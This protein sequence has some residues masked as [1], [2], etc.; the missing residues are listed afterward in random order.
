MDIR[1]R[2]ISFLQVKGPSLPVHIAKEIGQDSV[3]A[4]AHLSEMASQKKIAISNLKVGGSPLYYLP[5]QENRLQSF[6]HNLHEREQ[7]AVTLLREGVVLEDT[8]AIPVVRAA[9][10][11]LRDF[12][13][14]LQVTSQGTTKLFWKWYLADDTTTRAKIEA[15]L[16]PVQPAPAI[17]KEQAT[18]LRKDTAAKKPEEMAEQKT[19]PTPI[20]PRSAVP[21]PAAQKPKEAAP[22]QTLQEPLP[23]K[24]KG[25]DLFLAKILEYFS[26]EKIKV[27][28]Q[29]V[30]RNGKEYDFVI[31]MPSAVGQLLYYVKA[32]NKKSITDGDLASAHI[33]GQM[34]KLP[35]LILT[36]GQLTKKAKEIQMAELKGISVVNRPWE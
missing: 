27:M 3:M 18:P 20:V 17:R 36:P 32:R 25:S 21:K 8:K 12:A 23:E 2:I 29:I 16:K 15:L 28:E 13:I 6:V 24:P 31:S 10:R 26:S 4:S 9:L 5:G 1:D 14:P 7:E 11:S 19:L 22:Q 30:I 33:Q 34:K 35:V